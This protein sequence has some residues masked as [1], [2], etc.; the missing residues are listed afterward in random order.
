MPKHGKDGFERLI[1]N[2]VFKRLTGNDG[3]E[4]LNRDH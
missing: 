1:G 2:D 4:W 3:S